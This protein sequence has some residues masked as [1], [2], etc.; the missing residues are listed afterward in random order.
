MKNARRVGMYFLLPMILLAL[1][2]TEAFGPRGY[3]RIVID[4]YP[5]FDGGSVDTYIELFDAIG[6]PDPLDDPWSTAD[7]ADALAWDD[8]GNPDHSSFARID[9]TPAV[10]A[11]S[12]DTFYIRVR[13]ATRPFDDVYVIRVL[14]PGIGDPLPAEIYP[15]APAAKPDSF[16][17]DD[18]AASNWVMIA[19][20]S[21]S[22]GNSNYR[23][24]SLDLNVAE[25]DIDWFKLVLP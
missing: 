7:Q 6:D 10:A 14:T 21:I 17:D 24:R 4:T 16:E 18:D 13:G 22:P 8:N 11:V 2:C 19:P 1:S 5:Y 20:V 12:G 25:D 15:G 3:E 23:N 9:Y